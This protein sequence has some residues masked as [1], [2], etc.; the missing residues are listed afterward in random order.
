MGDEIKP[1]VPVDTL[2]AEMARYSGHY[3]ESCDLMQQP[4]TLVIEA[5]YPPNS[6]KDQDGKG[7]PI[8]KPVLSFKGTSK[9]LILGATNERLV[10]ACL[11]RKASAWIGKSLK[12]SVRFLKEAFGQTNV[13]TIRVVLPPDVPMPFNC[14]KHYG[15][16]RPYS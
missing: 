16:D 6:R 4:A 10:K 8:D 7:R 9:E 12:L 13:P 11:G 2:D 1:E 14:R 15:A 5:V 3:L